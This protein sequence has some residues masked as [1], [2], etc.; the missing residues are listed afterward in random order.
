VLKRIVFLEELRPGA[1]FALLALRFAVGAFLI[2]G[3]WDNI[4]GTA[5]MAEFAAF[6]RQHGFAA[7]ELLAPL[8][9][10]AQFGCGAAFVLG[11]F[12][13]WAGLVCAFNFIVALVMVDAALGVRAAFP[14][15]MLI[16]VGLYL[17]ANGGGRFALDSLFARNA[18]AP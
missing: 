13:R 5:R 16:L 6:L 4:V 3:V 18:T 2:W 10:W 9:V 12:T 11:L 7:P 1:D 17:S 15:T 8:S 14:S